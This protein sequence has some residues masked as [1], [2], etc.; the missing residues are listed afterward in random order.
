M[1]DNSTYRGCRTSALQEAQRCP[2]ACQKTYR[3]K[4]QGGTNSPAITG[5]ALHD[6]LEDY[7]NHCLTTKYDTDYDYFESIYRKHII[8]VPPE[9]YNDALRIARNLKEATNFSAGI[10]AK[11]AFVERRIFIDIHGNLVEPNDPDLFFASGIDY[12]YIKNTEEGYKAYVED[13]KSYRLIP[14]KV[15]SDSN[16]IIFVFLG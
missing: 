16:R 7:G 3:D 14:T 10:K 2:F 6:L 15:A 12:Y 4:V 1:G 9:M 11:A 13:Y 8:R 5:T